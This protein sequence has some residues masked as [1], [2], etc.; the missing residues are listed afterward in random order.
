MR[1]A[2]CCI[3]HHA[4]KNI[5]D[6]ARLFAPQRGVICGKRNTMVTRMIGSG[7]RKSNGFTL[8]FQADAVT[9]LALIQRTMAAGTGIGDMVDA[10]LRG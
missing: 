8:Q 9:R 1:D 2:L 4:R 3:I 5:G 10:L 7:F 6:I